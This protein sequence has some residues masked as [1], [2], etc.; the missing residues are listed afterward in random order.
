[1]SIVPPSGTSVKVFRPFQEE[2]YPNVPC[3][4]TVTSSPFL[5]QVKPSLIPSEPSVSR[6]RTDNPDSISRYAAMRN[7]EYP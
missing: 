6:Y 5:S 1:M 2:S 3:P 7:A 4:V